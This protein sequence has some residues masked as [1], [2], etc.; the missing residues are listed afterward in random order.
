VTSGALLELFNVWKPRGVQVAL[1]YILE[2]HA[3]DEWPI[4]DTST[5]FEQHKCLDDRREAAE[6]TI[7]QYPCLRDAE[8]FGDNIF[9][10]NESN[11]FNTK[12]ASWPLRYWILH[13]GKVAFKAMPEEATYKLERVHDA[14]LNILPQHERSDKD[15]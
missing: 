13:H 4:R 9:L 1:V 5:T 10:D 3:S 6:F 2:A 14:L 11:D 8:Y 7:R 15:N 12:Y